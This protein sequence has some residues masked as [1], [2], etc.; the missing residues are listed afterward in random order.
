MIRDNGCGF[1]PT[2]ALLG[3]GIRSMQ[4]RA[5][6][7]GSQLNLESI[8]GE[9]TIITLALKLNNSLSYTEENRSHE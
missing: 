6:T 8:A 4:E 1:D 5:K 2:Q 3:F 9:G 7:L